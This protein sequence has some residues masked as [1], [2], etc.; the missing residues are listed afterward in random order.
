MFIWY[1]PG[2]DPG[3]IIAGTSH[4]RE[5]TCWD[6]VC[7]N[8][9]AGIRVLS[10]FGTNEV[11]FEKREGINEVRTSEPKRIIVF[12]TKGFLRWGLKYLRFDQNVKIDINSIYQRA[13]LL[14]LIKI[15]FSNLNTPCMDLKTS[16]MD[17]KMIF[18]CLEWI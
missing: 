2:P 17:L 6:T 10:F 12:F 11:L 14:F 3:N 8:A 18:K 5:T 7:R 16:K 15:K 1:R 9:I 4:C 13:I